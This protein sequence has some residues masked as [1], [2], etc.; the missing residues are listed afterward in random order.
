M[1]QEICGQDGRYLLASLPEPL[2]GPSAGRNLGLAL[3]RGEFISYLDSDDLFAAH[4]LETQLAMFDE[5]PQLDFVNCRYAVFN[6][7]LDDVL[8]PPYPPPSHHLEYLLL[9]A[10]EISP[11]QSGCP[12]WRTEKLRKIGGWDETLFNAEDL[13]LF[14][15]A[16]AAGLS[17][18]RVEETLY[19]LRRGDQERLSDRSRLTREEQRRR[20]YLKSWPL[21]EGAGLATDLRRQ[22]CGANFYRRALVLG[23]SGRRVTALRDY[24]SDSRAIGL[25]WSRTLLGAGLLFC[26]YFQILTPLAARLKQ[27][28]FAHRQALPPLMPGLTTAPAPPQMLVQPL[29]V[30]PL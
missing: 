18:A 23:Q 17:S 6:S 11:W 7:S 26:R 28:Y 13:E 3:A 8:Q 29:S 5:S 4:K 24:V 9:G 2:R 14:L 19:F 10:E 25:S 12:L 22:L 27:P 21:L 1:A 30:N 15:R 16:E 20:L